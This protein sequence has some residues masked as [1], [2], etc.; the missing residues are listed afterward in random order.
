MMALQV[1]QKVC[2]EDCGPRSTQAEGREERK[3]GEKQTR[4]DIF[5]KWLSQHN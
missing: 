4:L 2:G 3:E 5:S 1:E